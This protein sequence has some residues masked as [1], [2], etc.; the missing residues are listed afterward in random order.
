MD[1]YTPWLEPAKAL[2]NDLDVLEKESVI[3]ALAIALRNEYG[4]GY[5]EGYNAGTTDI[6]RMDDERL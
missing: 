4:T 6:S 2:L 1:I 5:H 3:H